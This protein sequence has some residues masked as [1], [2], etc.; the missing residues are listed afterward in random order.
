MTSRE[1]DP[2]GLD[3]YGHLLPGHEDAVNDALEAMAL[4]AA[5]AE[6]PPVRAM[7]ERWTSGDRSAV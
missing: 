4:G 3:R 2:F 7:D 5:S 6:P 1:R